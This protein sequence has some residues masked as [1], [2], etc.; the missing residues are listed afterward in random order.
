MDHGEVFEQPPT[1][2][3]FDLSVRGNV[4]TLRKVSVH[5]LVLRQPLTYL[6]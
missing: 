5:I 3:Y 6:E 4:V 2:R 1:L